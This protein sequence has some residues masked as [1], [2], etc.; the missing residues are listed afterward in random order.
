MRFLIDAQLP[1]ALARWLA[2]QGCEAEHVFDLGLAGAEDRT[3][4]EH[5]VLHDLVIVTKDED[6]ALRRALETKGP[7]IVWIRVG[8]TRTGPLLRWFTPLLGD[9]MAA[10]KR[11]EMLI[12]IG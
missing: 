12:E 5:A 10:L 6:F 4:W 11:G 2:K 7:A 3:I 1:P 8:N 9:I